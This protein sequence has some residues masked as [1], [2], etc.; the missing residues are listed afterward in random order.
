V[1][2]RPYFLTWQLAPYFLQLYGRAPTTTGSSLLGAL[3]FGKFKDFKN[4]HINLCL[5]N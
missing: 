4:I 1:P 5:N 3:V 2:A